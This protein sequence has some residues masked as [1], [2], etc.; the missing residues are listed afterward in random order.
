MWEVASGFVKFGTSDAVFA[1]LKQSVALSSIM[2]DST[3]QGA[4]GAYDPDLYDAL[5]L[6]NIIAA[7]TTSKYGNGSESVFEMNTDTASEAY[8]RTCS[9]IPLATGKSAGGSTDF[10]NDYLREYWRDL[11]APIVGGDWDYGSVAGVF[12]LNLDYARTNSYSSVGGRASY[13]L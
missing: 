10:G 11:M 1:T 13:L 3:T 5:D 12:T 9:G 6:T 2:N 8:V 7:D 4:G